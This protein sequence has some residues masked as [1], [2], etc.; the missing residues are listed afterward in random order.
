M[1]IVPFR[2]DVPQA[3]VE[4]LTE[5]L[6]RTRWPDAIA[7]GGWAYGIDAGYARDLVDSWA[8]FDWRAYEAS[9][10]A[11]PHFK[12]EIDGF[13]LHFLHIRGKGPAPKPLLL[14]HGWPS[15]FVEWLGLI[16]PL[17]DPAAFGGDPSDSFD[18]IIPSL[19]GYGFSEIP[20][21]PGMTPRRIAELWVS[22]MEELGYPRFAAHGC[23]WGSY[24]TSLI[25]LDH[26][27]R[28]MGI[29]T[30][31]VGL[32]VE[33]DDAERSER[34]PEQLEWA[35]RR[36]RWLQREAGYSAIQATKPQTLAYGLTDSP[37]GLAAW[38]GEKWWAWSD[39]ADPSCAIPRETLLG[40]IA[41]YWFTGTI[42]S[43][44][45]LY[46]ESDRAPVR[47]PR[48]QRVEPP[49]GFFLECPVASRGKGGVDRP[50]P[51]TGPRRRADEAFDVQ[52][53]RVAPRGGHFPALETPDLLVS[54]LRDFFRPL[55]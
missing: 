10:N 34:T 40:N 28:V 43:A 33:A 37:A 15:S 1:G 9:L 35:R 8:R 4:D 14:T 2:I 31:S 47:V 38:I 26:P 49:A 13:N 53:W 52:R 44:C 18:V 30:A 27:D 55:K 3:A 24:I 20:Q 29:H 46:Y 36:K 32:S 16:G 11:Y 19:P 54:E 25:G 51:D 21:Q 39:H 6:R 23:D 12:A 42:N 22:L 50:S 7:G 41:V 45:R 17:T 5:R 48:G